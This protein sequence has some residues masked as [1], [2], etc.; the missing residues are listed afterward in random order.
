MGVIVIKRSKTG[1]YRYHHRHDNGKYNLS[2]AHTKYVKSLYIPKSWDNV[3]LY[4]GHP[5][6]I[7]T[8]EL[9]GITRYLYKKDFTESQKQSK[10][11]RLYN[12][13]KIV[14][15]IKLDVVEYLDRSF[16]W[17]DTETLIV[18][19]LWFLLASSARVGNDRYC[20]KNDTYGILSL[21]PRHLSIKN[22]TT[23]VLNFVGKKSV[24]NHYEIP[25]PNGRVL[26]WLKHLKKNQ[27]WIFAIEE[28]RLT[29]D[30]LNE[31]IREKY[32]PFTAKDFR[33]WGAN[34]HFI[35]Q[36][37]ECFSPVE[38]QKEK[39]KQLKT[40]VEKTAMCLNNTASVC[41]NNYI[42]PEL[43]ETFKKSPEKMFTSKVSDKYQIIMDCLKKYSE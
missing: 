2:A 3:L 9:K 19:A 28:F 24:K 20:K 27:E 29:P 23:L 10:F 21:Q 4:I 22:N 11:R 41:K 15:T 18:T 17:N 36:V 5:R 43:L 31:Y 40:I 35:N 1:K 16:D 39:K 14:N 8:G 7:A 26:E 42:C 32:G 30:L 25:I 34:E 12:F 33:T 13:G 38:T 6:L 37:N